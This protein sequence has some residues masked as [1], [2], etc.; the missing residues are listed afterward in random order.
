MDWPTL[1]LEQPKISSLLVMS[2]LVC[3]R[4]KVQ[5]HTIA[6]L[7]RF[8]TLD[9]HFDKVV[10]DLV[11]PLPPF[12]GYAYL[13]MCIDCFSRWPEAVPIPNISAETVAEAFVTTWVARFRDPSTLIT[14]LGSQ[15]ES[16]LWE[17]LMCLLETA[18]L[19][20]GIAPN[21]IWHY[22]AFSLPAQSCP[23]M[24]T[25]YSTAEL[26]NGTI[27]RLQVEI[28]DL[29][30][31]DNGTDATFYVSKLCDSMQQ[32]R[33]LP[34]RSPSTD[35]HTWKRIWN[36]AP[37]FSYFTTQYTRLYSLRTMGR[38]KSCSATPSNLS[39]TSMARN[40]LSHLTA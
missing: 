7:I 25:K 40:A 10:L 35:E 1:A 30:P 22:R 28:F 23:Q 13:L 38:M 27:L 6:P 37:M 9:A 4:S 3:Q 26:V 2:G 14:D 11:G 31:G 18:C 5:R 21:L 34:T 39:S 24:S 29:P 20:N 36:P 15:F 8:P 16:S 19:H 33:T 12:K 32:L 17:H